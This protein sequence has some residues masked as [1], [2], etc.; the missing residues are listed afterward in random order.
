M[1]S[2]FKF[3]ASPFDCLNPDEQRLVLDNV[4][5]VRFPEGAT[6]LELGAAPAHLFVIIQGC[7]TQF[8]G[9]EVLTT[10]AVSY[11]HL[12]VYKRQG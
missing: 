10:Y 8:D 1:P 9:N 12:D 6:I 3:S 2:D 5:E 7:V 11:T 4:H